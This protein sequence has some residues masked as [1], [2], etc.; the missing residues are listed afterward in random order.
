MFMR[1]TGW[2]PAGVGSYVSNVTRRG[3]VP[4]LK[5]LGRDHRKFGALAGH[6]PA[7]GEALIVTLRHFSG[8]NWTDKLEEDWTAAYGLVAQAMLA[9]ADEAAASQPPFWAGEIVA[10]EHA[11]STSRLSGS[12]RTSRRRTGPGSPCRW[13]WRTCAHVSGAGI[14][15]RRSREARSSRSTPASSTAARCRPPWSPA[16]LWVPGSDSARPSAGWSWT[17]S[18]SVRCS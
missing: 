17:T 11:R 2:G 4:F 16:P 1:M 6:Y 12:A 15:R 7:V 18:L 5:D 3:I 8:A 14:R 13:S 10:V 9:A